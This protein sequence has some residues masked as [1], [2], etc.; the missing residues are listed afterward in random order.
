[1]IRKK[2]VALLGQMFHTK[3]ILIIFCAF[4]HWERTIFLWDNFM[5]YCLCLWIF[6]ENSLQCYMDEVF[7]TIKTF[8]KITSKKVADIFVENFGKTAVFTF[9]W[10]KKTLMFSLNIKNTINRITSRFISK[11]FSI[12]AVIVLIIQ[13]IINTQKLNYS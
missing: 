10:K 4:F 3:G 9:L 13:K 7:W 12:N 11:V 5:F 2:F 8:V 6:K 1:M